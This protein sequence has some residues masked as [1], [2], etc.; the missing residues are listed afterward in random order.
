MVTLTNLLGNKIHEVQ[1]SWTTWKDLE[2]AHQYAKSSPKDIHFFRVV[3]PT[4]LPK[5]LG[6]KGSILSKPCGSVPD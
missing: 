5:V 3:S 4:E 6:L 2:A 1:E